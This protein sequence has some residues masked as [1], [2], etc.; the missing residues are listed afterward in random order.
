MPK[1]RVYMAASVDG[2]IAELDRYLADGGLM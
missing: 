2:Y 1:Y